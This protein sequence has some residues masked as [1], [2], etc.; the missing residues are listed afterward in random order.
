MTSK[1]LLQINP[2]RDLN[3]QAAILLDAA[4]EMKERAEALK[5]GNVA[6]GFERRIRARLSR[7]AGCEYN[8]AIDLFRDLW[9]RR[10]G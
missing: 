2:V 6:N 4:R 1:S 7:E 9:R 8:E 5:N 3:K 10:E